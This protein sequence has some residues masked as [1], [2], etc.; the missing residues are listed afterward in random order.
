MTGPLRIFLA[1][2]ASDSRKF[3]MMPIAKGARNN[4]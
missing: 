2:L 1:K 4:A 3:D